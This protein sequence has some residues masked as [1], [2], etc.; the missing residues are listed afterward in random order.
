MA[1]VIVPAD[2][3]YDERLLATVNGHASS[4]NTHPLLAASSTTRA[5]IG[6][7]EEPP[8]FDDAGRSRSHSRQGCQ[9]CIHQPVCCV[10]LEN[11]KGGSGQK[12]AFRFQLLDHRHCSFLL[13]ELRKMAR[14]SGPSDHRGSPEHVPTD[15]L[16]G[17]CFVGFVTDQLYQTLR[18]CHSHGFVR[19]FNGR[20]CRREA[21][22]CLLAQRTSMYD[23]RAGC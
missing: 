4:V 8:L 17:R 6:A 10:F 11:L 7:G 15:T 2:G 13:V 16:Q 14:N 3:A 19:Q 21:S 1:P 5:E 20:Q 23:D 18:G 22:C 9:H 12:C